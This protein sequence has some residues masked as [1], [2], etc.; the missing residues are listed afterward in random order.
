MFP[1]ELRAFHVVAQTGSI[2]RASET[3]GVAPSSVS[4]KIA[5]LEHQIGTTLLERTSAGVVLTHAGTL[6]AE[7]A[8]AV[9]LDYESLRADLNDRRGSR[10]RLVALAVVESAVSGGLVDAIAA[11]RSKFEA[12]YFR[13]NIMPA[14]QVVE[15]VKRGH[16]ELGLTF[17][18]PRQPDIVTVAS[19]VE[20]IVLAVPNNHS[21]GGAASVTLNELKDV[22]LALPELSFGV[23]RILDR[24]SQDIGLG[25]TANPAFSSN[26]FEAL[27]DFVRAGAGVAVLP[28][29]AVLRESQLGNMKIVPIDHPSFKDTTID[30]ITLRKRRISSVVND[31]IQELVKTF[32]V[33]VEPVE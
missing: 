24:A 18:C 32:E 22:A 1:G 10:R 11:F 26:S 29:R 27:R 21:L 14:P 33:N 7:Y 23:R 8:R 12:V 4:R 15:D 20:P 30:I 2:R 3:L 28:Q 13:L 9:V 25:V 6:V 17:C 31:F 5:L 16:Y 19:I